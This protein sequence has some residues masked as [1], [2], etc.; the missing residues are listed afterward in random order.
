M[1]IDVFISHHTDSSLHIVEAI[2]NKLESNGIKCWYAPRNTE[3]DYAGSIARAIKQCKVFLL[4]LNKDASES[5]HVLN[6]LNAV[7]KRLTKKEEVHILPFHTADDEISDEADY[8]VGRMHWID[9]MTPPM[10]KRIDELVEKIASILNKN[11]RKALSL[12]GGSDYKII[13][14]IPQVR[15]VFFGRD[16]LIE[17]INGVFESGNRVVFLEGIGGIG[18]SETA[19][20]YAVRYKS[21]YKNIVFATYNDSIKKLICDPTAFEIQGYEQANKNEEEFF[22]NKLQIIRSVCDEKTLFII[23]NFDVDDDEELESF[24]T[25]RH[26]V[27]F[28]SRNSHCGFPA[29]KIESIKDEKVLVKIFEQNYG[30][31][32]PNEDIPWLEKIFDL[33]E[34]HTY[35]IELIAKQMEASF[36]TAKEMYELL[37]EGKLQ[38][39]VS[40]AVKGRKQTGTAFEHL[41]TLFDTNRLNDEEKRVMRA[42]SLIGNKGIAV[43]NFKAWC[44]LSDMSTVTRLIHRSWIRKESGQRISLHPLMT[45]VVKESLRPDIENTKEFLWQVA[46]FAY[47]AWLRVYEENLNAADN[48]YSILSYYFPFDARGVKY[49][50]PMISFLWQ[51]GRFDDSIR[52]SHE[53]YSVC[54]REYGEASMHT[55]FAAKSLAGAYFNSRREKESV[56]WYEQGLKC[57]KLSGAED[58]EDLAMAYSKVAR[59]CTFD[60]NSDKDKAEEYFNIALNMRFKIR[61]C[62]LRG[63]NPPECYENEFRNFNVDAANERIG[64]TYME[65]GRMYQHFEEYDKALEYALKYK[66][67][68][69]KFCKN[70]LSGYAY[71]LYDIGLCHYKI[72]LQKGDAESDLEFTTAENNLKEAL[73]INMEMRGGLANDTIEN[74]ELL[75]DLYTAMK[76]FGDASNSYIAAIS[77]LEKL[78]SPEYDKIMKIKEKM[79]F[80]KN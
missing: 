45:E 30:D 66:D 14:K 28:T 50:E 34:N 55:G 25:G 38:T 11:V 74:C 64:E 6:E 57:M 78:Y 48:I 59:C 53:L 4:I 5:V 26:R 18:K 44:E 42:L 33:I 58:C 43:K 68:I 63:G 27:I 62:F 77:M 72:G 70:N 76:R 24:L 52:Y 19:K 54:L 46:Y 39:D 29:I 65:I 49:F 17:K 23:D 8:Y 73:K 80:N 16:D 15:A 67:S 40:E 13:S 75:G 12:Q 36:L 22:E 35:M 20:Q 61:D 51:V 79:M 7:T 69:E 2:V 21:E 71:A 41:L 56:Q 60:F 10:Y 37:K 47:D 1:N 31:S 3:D 9:A 32:V